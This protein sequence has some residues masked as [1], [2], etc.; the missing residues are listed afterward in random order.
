MSEPFDVD[1]AIVGGGIVG[2]ATAYQLQSA[3]P[4]LRVAILEKE[5]ELATHQSGHNSGVLHAGLYYAPGSLKAR[6]CRE[7]KVELERFAEVHDIPIECCGKLVVALDEGELAQLAGLKERA[8]TKRRPRRRGGR[9]GPGS[10][11]SSRTPPGSG[12]Y[13][14][15]PRRS[16]TSGGSRLPWP[17][18]FGRAAR[19]S[20]SGDG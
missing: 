5:T 1:V 2:L 17:T 20:T 7:G 6:L 18:R 12:R 15:R 4:E 3:H 14:A 10:P 9:S 11:R 19:R 16:S 13:G 8:V